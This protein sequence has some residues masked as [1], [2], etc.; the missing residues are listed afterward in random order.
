MVN[1]ETC[2]LID[3]VDSFP[4]EPSPLA[5]HQLDNNLSCSDLTV[6]LD[7]VSTVSLHDAVILLR[8][9]FSSTRV[10]YVLECVSTPPDLTMFDEL[11]RKGV[12]RIAVGPAVWDG[13][14]GV[15]RIAPVAISDLTKHFRCVE[16][17]RFA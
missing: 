4:L 17:G 1:L 2:I 7:G 5:Y 16:L 10:Q 8:A 6:V 13:S 3:P 9:S 15:R 14:V 11:M 12:G